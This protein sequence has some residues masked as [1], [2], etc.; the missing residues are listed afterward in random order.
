MWNS[1]VHLKPSSPDVMELFHMIPQQIVLGPQGHFGLPYAGA[2]IRGLW[3]HLQGWH[4]LHPVAPLL[5][6]WWHPGRCRCGS[7]QPGCWRSTGRCRRPAAEARGCAAPRSAAPCTGGSAAC[8]GELSPC[9]TPGW[10]WEHLL[11]QKE[12]IIDLCKACFGSYPRFPVF[13]RQLFLF[14]PSCF[15]W[16]LCLILSMVITH[17]RTWGNKTSKY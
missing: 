17:C 10:G 8:W 2:E 15:R 16:R 9:T 5:T 14:L 6:H 13:L 11:K 1:G 12:I 3:G 4:P 7:P